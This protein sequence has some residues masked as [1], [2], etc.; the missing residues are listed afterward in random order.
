MSPKPA[1]RDPV[2]PGSRFRNRRGRGPPDGHVIDMPEHHLQARQLPGGA[3]RE[4]DWGQTIPPVSATARICSSVKCLTVSRRERAFPWE[5]ITGAVETSSVSQKLSSI[6][7][8]TSTS[9]PSPVH[10]ADDPPADG[11]QSSRASILGS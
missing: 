2:C 1:G 3:E 7:W 11:T 10:L 5:A 4:R 9:M 6:M 8:V